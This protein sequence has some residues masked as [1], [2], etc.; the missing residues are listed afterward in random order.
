ME[1]CALSHCLTDTHARTH[2]HKQN[3]LI[4]TKQNSRTT[5]LIFIIQTTPLQNP[6]SPD[7]AHHDPQSTILNHFL[8]NTLL[9]HSYARTHIFMDSG[10]YGRYLFQTTYSVKLETIGNTC[11][12]L[13]IQESHVLR[14]SLCQTIAFQELH[15]IKNTPSSRHYVLQNSLCP[16]Y[17]FFRSHVLQNLHTLYLHHLLQDLCSVT[18]TYVIRTDLCLSCHL[19]SRTHSLQIPYS[20]K[21]TISRTSTMSIIRSI[22]RIPSLQNQH[23]DQSQ[24]SQKKHILS[25]IHCLET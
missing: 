15:I 7:T 22:S 11:F 16:D 25:S 8:E 24:S 10:Q 3:L 23:Y 14:I 20:P 13:P 18:R 5:F 9:K 1:A 17:Q 6:C 4:R 2:L 12:H 21:P 19:L